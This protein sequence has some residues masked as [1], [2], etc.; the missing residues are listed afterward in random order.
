MVSG[1]ECFGRRGNCRSDM[2]LGEFLRLLEQ[3]GRTNYAAL[4]SDNLG[5]SNLVPRTL[6][7][8]ACSEDIQIFDAESLTKEK[9]R[10]IGKE[11]TLAP[12]GGSDLTHIF[13]RRLQ[14]IPSGSV[15]PLLKVVEEA[16]MA[17]FI[18]QAQM[19]SRKIQTLFSRAL[20][21]PLSFL[22]EKAVLGNMKLMNHDAL[23]A[24]NLRLYDGTLGGTIEMMG[25][26]DTVSAFKREMTLG[27]RG[28]VGLFGEDMLN[29]MA[30]RRIY[31]EKL[32]TEEQ[33]YLGRQDDLTRRKLIVYLV[34]GRQHEKS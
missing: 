32:K 31:Q 6:R 2:R 30:F 26:K 28:L 25:M 27:S 7:K 29:S 19:N 10:Q 33:M 22:S 15:G 13:I 17:R 16:R 12:Q 8:I 21:V 3:K 34:A 4:A 1:I 9:V 20:V 11:V 5:L 23:T 18:F 24:K 14:V